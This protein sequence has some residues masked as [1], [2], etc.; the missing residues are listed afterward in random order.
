MPAVLLEISF[1]KEKERGIILRGMWSLLN[2]RNDCRHGKTMID[3][4]VGNRI[5]TGGL[6]AACYG[7]L[8]GNRENRSSS[9]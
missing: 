5:G 3:P 1:C 8:V 4:G 7:P 9:G 2:S 6:L